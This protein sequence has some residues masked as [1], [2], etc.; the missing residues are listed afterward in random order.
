[1]FREAHDSLENTGVKAMN[2]VY[3]KT[4]RNPA[5]WVAAVAMLTIGGL[6]STGVVPTPAVAEDNP[7]AQTV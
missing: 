5:T 7:K 3:V 1:M 2:S 4:V 6:L